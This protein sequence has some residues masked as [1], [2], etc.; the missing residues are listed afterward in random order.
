MAA[1]D[2]RMLEAL[3]MP[4][5]TPMERAARSRAIADARIQLAAATNRRLNAAAVSRIDA[6]LGLTATD[7]RLG[8]P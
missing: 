7:P 3:Q 8:V 2:R 6:L 1:Y 4:T 5:G